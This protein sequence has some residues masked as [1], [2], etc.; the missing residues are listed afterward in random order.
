MSCLIHH[1]LTGTFPA[2]LPLLNL[3]LHSLFPNL[4]N[5]HHSLA[6]VKHLVNTYCISE[7]VTGETLYITENYLKQ[8]NAGQEEDEFEGHLDGRTDRIG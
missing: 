4:A 8:S 2:L 3:P 5:F 7:A 6:Y 1:I